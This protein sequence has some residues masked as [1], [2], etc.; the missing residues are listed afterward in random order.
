V[1]RLATVQLAA[2]RGALP[3]YK[4]TPR[5]ALLREAGIE[6]IDILLDSKAAAAAVRLR[7]L[8]QRHPLSRR[9]KKETPY[10]TRFQR[11]AKQTR[12]TEQVD[13]L[14]RPPWA[15]QEERHTALTR[16]GA[17]QGGGNATTAFQTWLRSRNP[18]DIVV[19]SDGSKNT[20]GQAG[21]GWA[22]YQAHRQFTR[23]CCPLPNAEVYDAEAVAALK[24]LQ[25]ACRLR[26][27]EHADN[28]FICLDNLEVAIQLLSIPTSS[29]QGIFREFQEAAEAWQARPR[30]S[31]TAPGNVKI[32]WCPGHC[33]IAGNEAADAAAK[34]GTALPADNTTGQTLAAAKRAAKEATFKA[35]SQVWATGAPQRYKDLCIR[36]KKRPAELQLPRYALGKLYAARTG[37]GDFAAYPRRFRHPDA[38]LE[39]SCSKEKA[40][41]HFFFCSKGRAAARK[42]G[43]KRTRQTL[44]RLLGTEAGARDFAEW[45]DKTKFFQDICPLKGPERRGTNSGQVPSSQP[46]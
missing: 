3:V 7:R 20:A 11:W 32:R 22:V 13:P 38:N 29:S 6:P 37:H 15:M 36:I 1:Q 23:G 19:F 39:C 14:P 45:L 40:P 25:A 8:D 43:W 18:R 31:Y 33:G 46:Y 4:T 41:L 12:R 42:A 21:A 17:S 34:E 26:T 28:V 44:D 35:F 30:H 9:A 16:I 24:G 27:A 10:E 5:L 2:I